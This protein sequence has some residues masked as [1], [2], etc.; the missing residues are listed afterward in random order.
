MA[1]TIGTVAALVA[2]D[3]APEDPVATTVEVSVCPTSLET[4]TYVAA[5]APAIGASFPTMI[6]KEVAPVQVLVVDARAWPT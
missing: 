3:F 5:V 6:G 2:D 4:G 1:A